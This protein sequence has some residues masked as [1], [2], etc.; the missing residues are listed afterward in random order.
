M[1][2][3]PSEYGAV[4]GDDETADD[5]YDQTTMTIKDQSPP[6]YMEVTP[7]QGAHHFDRVQQ[8]FTPLK[9][10]EATYICLTQNYPVFDRVYA[11]KKPDTPVADGGPKRKIYMLQVRIH[12]SQKRKKK[13]FL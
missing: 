7:G 10:P 6:V 13:F 2:L 12:I 8:L 9:S 1:P 4:T 5:R 11:E 3:V